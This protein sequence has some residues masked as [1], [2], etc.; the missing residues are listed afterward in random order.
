MFFIIIYYIIKKY[1][2]HIYAGLSSALSWEGKSSCPEPYR[3]VGSTLYSFASLR[4][5][6]NERHC[7]GTVISRNAILFAAYCIYGHHL[8]PD[9]GKLRIVVE[10]V[11]VQ[12]R[13]MIPHRSYNPWEQK[14]DVGVVRV[15]CL[16][17]Y[18]NEQCSG[19][20]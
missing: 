2:F 11:E 19:S 1:N 12:I 14:F 9:F 10:R 13:E 18:Y 3:L 15:S 5:Y 20:I 8:Q 7:T 16:T 4:T 6:R 17:N